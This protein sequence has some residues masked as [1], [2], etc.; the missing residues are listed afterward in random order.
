MLFAKQ[1][2]VWFEAILETYN[3]V[4]YKVFSNGILVQYVVAHAHKL[5]LVFHFGFQKAL[6]NVGINN[7]HGVFVKAKCK[8]GYPINNVVQKTL[9]FANLNFYAS[10]C[11]YPLDNA[12]NFYA[13]CVATRL[14]VWHNGT[15]NFHNFA[16]V[17][18]NN[19]I[20]MDDVGTLQTYVAIG[21]VADADTLILWPR[22][23][24]SQLVG[25]DLDAGK[26]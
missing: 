2:F 14:G 11:V 18:Q 5:E 6:F 3:F 10:L 16:L 12:L 23:T 22:D 4:E 24:K 8:V 15:S 19:V 26:D 7:L 21:P 20:A 13:T 1:L 17:V 9:E 25:K